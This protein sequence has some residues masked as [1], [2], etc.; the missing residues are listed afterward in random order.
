MV[1]IGYRWKGGDGG[2]ILNDIRRGYNLYKRPRF[3]RERERDVR[4][5][6]SDDI[7][8]PGE[9]ASQTHGVSGSILRALAF[10]SSLECLSYWR[11]AKGG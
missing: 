7:I 6:T 5:V 10:T 9:V 8:G 3:W 4:V 11:V 2:E 1:I